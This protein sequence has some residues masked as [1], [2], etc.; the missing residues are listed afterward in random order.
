MSIKISV[1][2]PVY[3]TEQYVL[4]CLASIEKQ[5]FQEMEIIL[6]DDGSTDSSGALCDEYAKNHT[7]VTVVHKAN[8]G[9]SDSRN[10]GLK[11]ARGE[12]VHF[13][14]SDDVV[15]DENAYINFINNVMPYS[16]DIMFSRCITYSANLSKIEQ[17][18]PNYDTDG[19]FRG[20][21]LLEVLEKKYQLTLTSPVN[22][23]FKREFLISNSLFFKEGLSHE[24]DEWLPRVVANAKTVWFDNH[25]LYGAR[26][27][28]EGS[29]SQ[30]N[31]DVSKQKKACSKMYIA[32]SGMK[33]MQARDLND[34]T[35]RMVT[36]HYWGY[37]IDACVSVNQISD[38]KLR[39]I[40]ISTIKNNRDFFKC[41]KYLN[42]KNWRIM[43]QMFLCLG[44]KFTMKILLVRYVK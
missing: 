37:M 42:N 32:S 13:V 17:I 4:E 38:K 27:G 3:N 1:I 8:G 19:L 7:Y 40:V 23:L 18:Q 12:Y 39:S 25:L 43:G 9:A 14:D 2:I 6:V 30:V 31:D 33:Y 36:E 28:R 5:S 29:L 21:V 15:N 26:C 34:R 11:T 10:V 41:Y 16:P 44:I 20:N 22:K 24:E 35:L